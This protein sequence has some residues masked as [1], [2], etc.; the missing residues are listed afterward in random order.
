MLFPT[1]ATFV[2]A[3]LL[4]SAYAATLPQTNGAIVGVPM[5]IDETPVP[6]TTSDPYFGDNLPPMIE[7]EQV[8]SH[9]LVERQAR[10][11]APSGARGSLQWI[12]MKAHNDFR[13]KYDAPPMAWNKTLVAAAQKWGNG[14]Q[15]KHSGGVLG[16]FGENLAV[17]LPSAIF[18]YNF[19]IVTIFLI[20]FRFFRL[21]LETTTSL[22]ES[23]CGTMKLLIILPILPI[24]RKSFLHIFDSLIKPI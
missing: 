20:S 1:T 19:S 24:T 10:Q 11:P 15:F 17:S 16:P 23:K 7:I 2:L 18:H 13:A 22:K 14:C 12:A 9:T 6:S 4:S 5:S 3:S 21:C 8:P